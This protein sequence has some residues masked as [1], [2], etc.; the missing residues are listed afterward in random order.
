MESP[1]T[2]A[3]MSHSYSLSLNDINETVPDHIYALYSQWAKEINFYAPESTDSLM[4]V[5]APQQTLNE[6]EYAIYNGLMERYVGLYTEVHA[7]WHEML[8]E[9]TE[10]DQYRNLTIPELEMLKR[11]YFLFRWCVLGTAGELL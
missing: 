7:Q 3:E 8:Y 5:D 10:Q 4:E 2:R 11:Y 1:P 9:R 6:N